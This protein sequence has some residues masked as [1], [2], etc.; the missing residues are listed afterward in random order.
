[1]S[2]FAELPASQHAAFVREASARLG[3]SPVIV[4]KDFWVCWM[5]QRIFQSSAA[6]AHL[7]FKGGTSLSKVFGAIKRFSEDIDHSIA[8]ELL[9]WA[10][11]GNG[12]GMWA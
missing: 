8:P 1:M 2:L 11:F 6:R 7:V 9:G 10:V 4:E 12:G 5:L 3:V